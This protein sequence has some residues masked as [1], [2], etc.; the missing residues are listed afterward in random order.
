M[1]T[2]LATVVLICCLVLVQRPSLANEVRH[3]APTAQMLDM[4]LSQIKSAQTIV[5]CDFRLPGG[6]VITKVIRGDPKHV[7][8][9]QLWNSRTFPHKPILIFERTSDH[10][11][12]GQADLMTSGYFE[13]DASK[14]F[15]V[16][17]LLTSKDSEKH[18]ALVPLEDLEKALTKKMVEQ[19]VPSDGHKPSSHASS[20]DPTAPADAH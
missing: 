19:A 7:Q 16:L 3:S 4:A 12:G 6:T 15:I 5:I 10:L 13:L 8:V 2:T 1:K 11:G 20:T 18:T 14:R 9:G 17:N